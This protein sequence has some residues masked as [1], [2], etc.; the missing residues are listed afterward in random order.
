MANIELI[1]DYKPRIHINSVPHP[2]LTS[3][4]FEPVFWIRLLFLLS[5]V[6]H[7]F[8]ILFVQMK[9]LNIDI[10]VARLYP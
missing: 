6:F 1:V 4:I 9:T 7:D 2:L 10:F 8:I 3:L 5:F